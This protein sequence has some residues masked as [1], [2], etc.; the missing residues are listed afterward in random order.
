M[1][2]LYQILMRNLPG[3]SEQLKTDVQETELKLMV[4]K[5]K[6][7]QAVLM[8]QDEPNKGVSSDL[9]GKSWADRDPDWVSS[10]EIGISGEYLSELSTVFL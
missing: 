7:D 9:L 1:F 10:I 3:E 6:Q 8:W 2:F 5:K 4:V